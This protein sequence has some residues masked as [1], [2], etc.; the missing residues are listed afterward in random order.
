MLW[1]HL[2]WGSATLSGAY[3]KAVIPSSMSALQAFFSPPLHLHLP[4]VP[5]LIPDGRQYSKYKSKTAA[6]IH[7]LWIVTMKMVD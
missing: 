4:S 2:A 7:S 3:L 5:L 6:K 1:H